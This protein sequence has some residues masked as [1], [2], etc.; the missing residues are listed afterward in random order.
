MRRNITLT[1][2]FDIL[3]GPAGAIS[4]SKATRK[5]GGTLTVYDNMSIFCLQPHHQCRRTNGSLQEKHTVHNGKILHLDRYNE[6]Q[7]HLHIG[8][9][10]GKGKEHTEVDICRGDREGDAEDEVNREAVNLSQQNAHKEIDIEFRRAPDP[11]K[12]H[13]QPVIEVHRD[14][15]QQPGGGRVEHEA[16]HAPYLTAHYHGRVKGNITQKH[17]V[18][19]AH[20]PKHHIG[21][22][23]V[24]HQIGDRIAAEFSLQIVIDGISIQS[25]TRSFAYSI[26][27]FPE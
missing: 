11:L 9:E 17:G 13:T 14:E 3:I 26:S 25:K 18:D 24:F 20:K 1:C 27:Y 21:Y 15:R 2:C 5:I 19:R 10:R 4:R 16:D 6:E 8:E 23:N 7:Q 12:G 22:G